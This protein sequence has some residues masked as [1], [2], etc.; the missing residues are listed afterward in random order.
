MGFM[1]AAADPTD[2]EIETFL[3][4]TQCFENQLMAQ[5]ETDARAKNR[6][7]ET[8]IESCLEVA[9]DEYGNFDENELKNEL[10]K[11]GMSRLKTFLE[12]PKYR[13][14][15]I[16]KLPG[17]RAL[18]EKTFSDINF[19]EISRNI[20]KLNA[21][22]P[23][24]REIQEAWLK[25]AQVAHPEKNLAEAFSNITHEGGPQVDIAGAY[26]AFFSDEN[27]LVSKENREKILNFLTRQY[28]PTIPLLVLDTIDPKTSKTFLLPDTEKAEFTKDLPTDPLLAAAIKKD[29]EEYWEKVYRASIG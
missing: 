16:S 26:D 19:D 13:K 20:S 28:V 18:K 3:S 24:R 14:T 11:E 23:K 12:N 1:S 29:K 4:Q 8:Q 15:Y 10:K 6:A 17:G 22:N 7:Q 9:H 21:T 2:T 27:T 5:I 25:I